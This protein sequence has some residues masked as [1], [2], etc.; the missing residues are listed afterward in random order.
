MQNHENN[1]FNLMCSLYSLLET[2]WNSETIIMLSFI[3]SC[4]KFST[5]WQ[6]FGL[7]W[8]YIQ[9]ME[10]TSVVLSS[11]QQ[12]RPLLLLI[13]PISGKYQFLHAPL[14]VRLIVPIAPIFPCPPFQGYCFSKIT[15]GFL[16]SVPWDSL[17]PSDYKLAQSRPTRQSCIAGRFFGLQS[18]ISYKIYSEL[19]M[20]ALS[21]CGGPTESFQNFI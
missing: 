11:L 9:I 5:R 21:P 2:L 12:F 13:Y 18:M 16:G 19:L 14:I 10:N 17:V 6:V 1:I 3:H 8:K 7:I 20:H 4:Q 15:S